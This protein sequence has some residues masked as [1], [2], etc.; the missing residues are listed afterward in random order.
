MSIVSRC[1]ILRATVVAAPVAH[2]D[3][4]DKAD[5]AP[6]RRVRVREV[7]NMRCAR[8]TNWRIPRPKVRVGAIF[9][10]AVLGVDGR[11]SGYTQA[12]DKS[13]Y[14]RSAAKRSATS[15]A[16]GLF[17]ATSA[18]RCR[19][20]RNLR[21]ACTNDV[22]DVREFGRAASR[23]AIRPGCI[24]AVLL[25]LVRA[26]PFRKRATPSRRCQPR[27]FSPAREVAPS[28]LPTRTRVAGYLLQLPRTSFRRGRLT[29][30]SSWRDILESVGKRH[31]RHLPIRELS[32]GC[33]EDGTSL[34]ACCNYARSTMPI[35]RRLFIAAGAAAWLSALRSSRSEQWPTAAPPLRRAFRRPAAARRSSRA[36]GSR[37]VVEDAR[38]TCLPSTTSMRV[39]ATSVVAMAE[40]AGAP[41]THTLIHRPHRP[42]CQ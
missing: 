4:D 27:R 8:H 28:C 3:R 32:A 37:L 35:P 17:I 13:D 2:G 29:V 26:S 41:T 19:S 5:Q 12:V 38:Q 7:S 39:P 9:F 36:F 42:R 25:E 21:P 18:T 1:P 11:R 6:R 14:A 34:R 10:L 30:S 15:A 16:R 23:D 33:G 20:S 31:G 24:H 40:L 22:V